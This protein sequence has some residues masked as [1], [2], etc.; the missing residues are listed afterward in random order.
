MGWKEFLKKKIMAKLGIGLKTN[1]TDSEGFKL[2]QRGKR[3]RGNHPI[4][5]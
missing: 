5:L 1:L 4:Y 3:S 2:G